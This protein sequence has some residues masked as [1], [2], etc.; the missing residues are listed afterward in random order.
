MMDSR[1][2]YSRIPDCILPKTFFLHLLAGGYSRPSLPSEPL[3]SVLPEP[4]VCVESP[5]WFVPPV[6][7]LPSS[8]GVTSPVT[9][10]AFF[11]DASRFRLVALNSPV[12]RARSFSPAMF[13]VMLNSF[14]EAAPSLFLMPML[15]W[16]GRESSRRYPAEPVLLRSSPYR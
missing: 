12:P 3:L 11:R 1:G 7:S 9:A 5:P 10:V 8:G 4:P 13:L 2:C 14:S 15:K 16:R 6:L